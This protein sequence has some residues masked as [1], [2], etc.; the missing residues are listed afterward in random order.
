METFSVFCKP[1]PIL[2]FSFWIFLLPCFWLISFS[3]TGHSCPLAPL[4]LLLLPHSTLLFLCLPCYSPTFGF[5]IKPLPSLLRQL[6]SQEMFPS[7]DVLKLKDK[8]FCR[9]TSGELLWVPSVKT[10]KVHSSS[11]QGDNTKLDVNLLI[12]KLHDYYRRERLDD[13]LQWPFH[14]MQICIATLTLFY[15]H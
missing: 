12:E 3:H 10:E 5:Q 11:W 8:V 6:Q 13:D 1:N 2:M 9:K 15:N 14:P 7:L 4:L